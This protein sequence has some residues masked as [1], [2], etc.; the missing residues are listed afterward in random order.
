MA[1]IAQQRFIKRVQPAQTNNARRVFIVKAEDLVVVS[2]VVPVVDFYSAMLCV[3]WSSDCHQ[4][5]PV[6]C[7]V[8]LLRG[9]RVVLSEGHYW[10]MLPRAEE[11]LF[12]NTH[13]ND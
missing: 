10:V 4:G 13:T 9:A 3:M 5:E 8:V 6:Y 1:Y 11:N 7:G 2:L 12:T